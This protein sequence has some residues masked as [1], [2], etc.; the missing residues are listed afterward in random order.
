VHGY[1]PLQTGMA[2]LP[3]T[4]SFFGVNIFS[5]WLVGRIGPR[6]P[7]TFGALLDALGFALLLRLDHESSY[8]QMLP[9]FA[10]IPAG[11]GLG[12]PAMT[13]SVLHSVD[14][15]WA[16]TAAAVLNAARQ[17]AGA[18]GVAAFGALASGDDAR[19]VSGLHGA[20]LLSIALL[21]LAALTSFRRTASRAGHC[22]G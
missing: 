8:G 14:N 19:V 21:L 5:G 20:A 7:M 17:A 11:M 12:V 22:S 6:W 13:I 16:G 10:L 4:A 2:Y 9:A 15:R 18:I 1:G 3:L